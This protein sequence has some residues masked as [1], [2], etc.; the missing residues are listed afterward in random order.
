MYFILCISHIVISR[1]GDVEN[2]IRTEIIP[3]KCDFVVCQFGL[4]RS[5]WEKQESFGGKLYYRTYISFL[6]FLSGGFC[7]GSAGNPKPNSYFEWP[8]EKA[9]AVHLSLRQNKSCCI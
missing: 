6:F 7:L 8:Y 3:K 2:Y 5:H 9:E 1:L 4:V